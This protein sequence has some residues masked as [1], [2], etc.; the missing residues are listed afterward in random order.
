MIDDERQEGLPDS[1][2]ATSVTVSLRSEFDFLSELRHRAA[3]S[4]TSESRP[5]P[6]IGD[7]AA[8]IP[9]NSVRDSI[10]TT[11][12]LVE[13]VDFHRHFT[14]PSLLGHKA[15]AVSLSDIAAMGGRPRWALSAI[16]VPIDVWNSTFVDELYDGLLA[17]ADRYDVRLIGGDVSRTPDKIVIDSIVMGECDR[18]GSISRSGAKPGDLLFV[19]GTLG[20]AASGLR[21]LERGARVDK[22]TKDDEWHLVHE[23]LLRQLS[24]QPRVG[25]GLVL[26]QERLATA[27]IDISDGL[28]SDLHHVCQESNVGALVQAVS[29]PVDPLVSELCGR[30]ALDPL[31][32]AL[33]GG[34]DFELLFAVSPQDVSRLPRKVDGVPVTEIGE[35]RPSS[36]GV[37][38]SEGAHVWELKPQGWK[39]F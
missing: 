4:N 6:T 5:S 26:G 36:D 33:H 31:M 28:S 21:L 11:D 32:L 10:V 18:D 7:D 9:Q 13:D 35:V 30:R 8:V 19:T 22:V 38:L 20:A 39:H 29:V 27:M 16:G 34:E 1:Q 25:W 24:P 12:L 3:R 2:K 17:L 23:L 15:L 37:R 14:T